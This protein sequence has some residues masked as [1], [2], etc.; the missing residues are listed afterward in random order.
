MN[1]TFSKLIKPFRKLAAY[2][3]SPLPVGMTDFQKWCDDIVYLY[4]L[5]DNESLRWTLGAVILHLSPRKNGGTCY[6]KSKRFF[7]LTALKGA[8]NEIA[9]AYM[10]QLKEKQKAMIKAAQ[11]EESA[12]A[13]ESHVEVTTKLAV[14]T[15]DGQS[16]S[17]QQ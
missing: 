6:Y 5:P 9:H 11:D 4:D 12:K 14:V 2:F 10:E 16:Q 13:A 3:P 15:S 17:V 7:G 1:K 8:S